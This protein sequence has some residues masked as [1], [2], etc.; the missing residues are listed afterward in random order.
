MVEWLRRARQVRRD[1]EP[2]PALLGELFR[3]GA[4]KFVCPQCSTAGLAVA[5]PTADNDEDWGMARKC[6]GC[7]KPIPAERLEVCPN[8][9]LCTVCQA[10]SDRGGLAGPAEYCP[11]C[12]NLMVLRQSRAAGVT[13]YVMSCS[14]CRR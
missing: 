2:D 4:A 10:Q 12:V 3:V 5:P 14:G 9:T 11:R 7:G 13:R 8:T 6:E 1:A